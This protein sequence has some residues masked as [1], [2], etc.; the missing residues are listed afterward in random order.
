MTQP[1]NAAQQQRDRVPSSRPQPESGK[2]VDFGVTGNQAVV[3]STPPPITISKPFLTISSEP[4]LNLEPGL[5][6][7]KDWEGARERLRRGEFLCDFCGT[8]QPGIFLLSI[9]SKDRTSCYACLWFRRES[10]NCL[11]IANVFVVEYVRRCGLLRAMLKVLLSWYPSV[12]LI[13]TERATPL[14]LPAMKSCGFRF[15]ERMDR[16]KL[17]VNREK[18]V[19]P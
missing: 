16:W 2:P 7:L 5:H 4:S 11:S 15:D 17:E 18:K 3:P 12:V 19:L 6:D 13:V 1:T 14:A 9:L 8:C 10:G